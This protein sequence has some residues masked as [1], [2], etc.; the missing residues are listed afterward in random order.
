[1]A[2]PVVDAL[3]NR[4]GVPGRDPCRLCRAAFR[5]AAGDP[6]VDQDHAGAGDAVQRWRDGRGSPAQAEQL[7]PVTALIAL[8]GGVRATVFAGLMLAALGWAGVQS[9]R[10][11]N[12]QEDAAKS[13]R[14]AADAALRI[15]G[16]RALLVNVN[17]EADR[18]IAE[19]KARAAEGEQAAAEAE[20]EAARLQARLTDAKRPMQADKTDPTYA[21]Q[22]RIQLG[23]SI[24]LL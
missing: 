4:H 8:L 11:G 21:E 24:P 22:L 3:G 23:S 20:A 10:L 1:M 9:Y 14:A 19:A 2:A 15:E 7:V 5:L 17:A 13:A 12:A 6:G 16:F 18:Q